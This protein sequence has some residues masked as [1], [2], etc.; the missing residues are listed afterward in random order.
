M[1]HAIVWTFI[2]L[3]GWTAPALAQTDV[4]APTVQML[5]DEGYKVSEVRRTWL[6][7][8]LIVAKKGQTLREV[9]L[10]RRSGAILNDQVF[11][12]NPDTYMP[13]N[14]PGPDTPDPGDMGGPGGG[15]GPG[16]GP[17]GGGSGPGGF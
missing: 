9:V 10:N 11:N 2:L 4:T 8:I 14:P 17:G 5:Q 6:G 13:S 7:R 16:G 1:K 15:S 12:E 3:L